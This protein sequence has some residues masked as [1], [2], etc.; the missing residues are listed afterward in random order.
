[1]HKLLEF[2]RFLHVAAML[3]TKIVNYTKGANGAQVP[4]ETEMLWMQVLIDIML[5]YEPVPFTA[6][7]KQKAIQMYQLSL[8]RKM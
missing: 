4:C 6:T 7:R 1:M 8:T 3:N 2:A 5:G